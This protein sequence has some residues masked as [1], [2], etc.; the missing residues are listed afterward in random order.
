MT[1]WPASLATKLVERVVVVMKDGAACEAPSA[2][3]L[4]NQ[5]ARVAAG[6]KTTVVAFL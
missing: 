3:V 5:L 4:F 1:T 6:R 2:V